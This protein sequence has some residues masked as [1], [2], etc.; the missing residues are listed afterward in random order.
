MSRGWR[1]AA[2][3]AIILVFIALDAWSASASDWLWYC[4]IGLITA[5][6]GCA[7]GS[8][9]LFS[10]AMAAVLVVDAAWTLDVLC[11]ATGIL[12]TGMTAFV[13][14]PDQ[15]WSNRLATWHHVLVPLTGVP[16][17][18]RHGYDR[19]ALLPA[20]LVPVTAIGGVHV[21]MACGLL[22]PWS[23]T[24]FVDQSPFMGPDGDPLRGLG[25]IAFMIFGVVLPGHL[26]LARICPPPR[27]RH[28][29]A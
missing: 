11:A 9:R 3:L 19:A 10:A 6:A 22:P 28:D 14:D 24:N 27:P 15:P 17:I 20:A 7:A 26:I 18:L 1:P 4:R 8:L 2:I 12:D 5:A 16:V 29:L 23:E 25:H 13:C 21:G